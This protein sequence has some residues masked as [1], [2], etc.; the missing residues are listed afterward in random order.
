MDLTPN[1]PDTNRFARAARRARF[2]L[3][4]TLPPVLVFTD[5]ARSAPAIE[6]ASVLPRGWA[7]VF[8][9]YGGAGRYEIAAELSKIAHFRGFYLLIGADPELAVRV[10]AQGVHWPERLQ[11]DARNWS[12]RLPLN[13][14]SAHR[15][16]DVLGPQLPGID[17]RVLSTVFP[18]SSPR[19]GPAMGAGRFRSLS[20][21]ADIP[22]YALG[23]LSA[24][25][26]G[27]IA[28]GAGLAGVGQL[29]GSELEG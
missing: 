4:G 28:T 25:N 20:H 16:G 29:S 18:S 14:M 2:G 27:R 6:L 17:A 11:R 24:A 13:T 23:G 1:A 5:P 26:T 19:A 22:V 10:G 8:R 3:G 12:A 15:P 7:L 21:K 9:H